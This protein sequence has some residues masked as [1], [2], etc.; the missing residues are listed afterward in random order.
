MIANVRVLNAIENGS[1][2]HRTTERKTRRSRRLDPRMSEPTVFLLFT[3]L[4]SS[5]P[6]LAFP[7]RPLRQRSYR[8]PSAGCSFILP[9]SSLHFLPSSAFLGAKQ[10]VDHAHALYR[11]FHAVGQRYFAAN[12]ARKRLSLQSVLVAF[13]QRLS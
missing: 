3:H 11:V 5:A 1:F 2:C 12:R 8:R 9:P 7:L 13:R 4:V 10:R 6:F